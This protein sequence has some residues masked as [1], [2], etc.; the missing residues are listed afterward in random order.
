MMVSNG[1]VYPCSAAQRYGHLCL[2]SLND[3]TLESLI[4][5]ATGQAELRR[6]WING[7]LPPADVENWATECSYHIATMKNALA[8]DKR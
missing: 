5:R 6:L 1:D 7:P 3:E 4:E 8:L 2:G